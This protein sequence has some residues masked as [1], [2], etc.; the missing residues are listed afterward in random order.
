M[1]SLEE[2]AEDSHGRQPAIVST[3][4]SR[5]GIVIISDHRIHP[6]S[7]LRR[8]RRR[9]KGL[10]LTCGYNLTGLTENRCPEC[11]TEFEGS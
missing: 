9:R 11:A 6:W 10:C 5:P 1:S 7:P 8:F 2:A 3:T 4:S